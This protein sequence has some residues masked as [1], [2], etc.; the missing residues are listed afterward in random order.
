MLV[1]MLGASRDAALAEEDDDDEKGK[2]E[3]KGAPKPRELEEEEEKDEEEDQEEQDA[4]DPSNE[5]GDSESKEPSKKETAEEEVGEVHSVVGLAVRALYVP[6]AGATALIIS[7]CVCSV[8]LNPKYLCVFEA[9]WMPCQKEDFE[10][11]RPNH[12]TEI[13][14]TP[15]TASSASNVSRRSSTGSSSEAEPVGMTMCPSRA[16]IKACGPGSGALVSLS[17]T[18]CGAQHC[19]P[20]CPRVHSST[21]RK[22][23]CAR[24]AAKEDA[25]PGCRSR[26]QIFPAHASSPRTGARPCLRQQWG[27]SC[28]AAA[29]TFRGLGTSTS[30]AHHTQ[31]GPRPG[32]WQSVFA[33]DME[34]RHAQDY[35]DTQSCTHT[36]TRDLASACRRHPG[37][38]ALTFWSCSLPC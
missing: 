1:R 33:T 6:T 13:G 14:G 29:G 28:G 3:E 35:G 2:A 22:G 21:Q 31:Q 5:S 10:M 32:V 8:T 26:A 36:H 9:G 25:V 23:M 27:L 38:A 16:S 34:H 19:W 12:E 20:A 4:R 7:S 37:R 30:L 24:T 17:K 15:H 18:R 11:Y